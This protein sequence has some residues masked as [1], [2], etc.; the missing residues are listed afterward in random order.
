MSDLFQAN[1]VFYAHPDGGAAAPGGPTSD[2][3]PRAALSPERARELRKHAVGT[4]FESLDNELTQI[5]SDLFDGNDRLF[6]LFPS[7]PRNAQAALALS[8]TDFTIIVR[9]PNGTPVA[10]VVPLASIQSIRLRPGSEQRPGALAVVTVGEGV[11]PPFPLETNMGWFRAVA[12]RRAIRQLQADRANGLVTRRAGELFSALR[13]EMSEVPP[14][15]APAAA[16]MA[17]AAVAQP[18]PQAQAQP[19]AQPQP[20]PVVQPAPQVVA[21]PQA[22]GTGQPGFPA[23]TGAPAVIPNHMLGRPVDIDN[24]QILDASPVGSQSAVA[25]QAAIG[26]AS[27]AGGGAAE[28]DWFLYR[29]DAEHGPYPFSTV[30]AWYESGEIDE[31]D[32]VR[33]ASMGEWITPDEAFNSGGGA[34]EAPRKQRRPAA[35]SGSG[36]GG[37]QRR[38]GGGGGG[39]RGGGGGGGRGGDDQRRRRPR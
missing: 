8:D 9:T 12:I 25:A 27:S 7:G 17:P 28:E 1:P 22:V 6:A 39:P 10:H 20:Q 19:Q 33:A 16:A 15:G 2:V 37:G 18:A 21:T 30:S 31:R 32:H 11:V 14:G 34:A 26:G 36:G 38:P 29:D 13:A 3:D 24:P 4:L 35:S 23:S 5:V